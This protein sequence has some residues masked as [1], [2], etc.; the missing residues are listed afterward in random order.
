MT[1][2]FVKYISCQVI[3]WKGKGVF[4]EDKASTPLY[5][6]IYPS[7][8]L[9]IALH[10]GIILHSYIICHRG[11]EFEKGLLRLRFWR[12][13]PKGERVLAQSKRTAP[14]HQFQKFYRKLF[15]IG[16]FQI[17]IPQRNYISLAYLKEEVF[18]NWYL[19]YLIFFQFVK[20][21]WTL[22]GEFH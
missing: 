10:F 3:D 15:S 22:R 9:H 1:N 21:S 18:K 4:G 5:H 11:R 7:S 2:V 14:P 17:S 12:L 19:K 13:M 16:I 20:P 6:V 8:S